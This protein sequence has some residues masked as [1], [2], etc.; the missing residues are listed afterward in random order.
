MLNTS[1][2]YFILLLFFS[3]ASNTALGN[4]LKPGVVI[5]LAWSGI[6]F[7]T[8]PIFALK[9]LVVAKALTSGIF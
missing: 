1:E 7:S 2:H 4:L 5:Y 9:T 3:F 8:F 6:L